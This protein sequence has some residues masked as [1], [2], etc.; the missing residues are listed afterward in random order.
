[1][2]AKEFVTGLFISLGKAGDGKL[3]NLVE[4]LSRHTDKLTAMEIAKTLSVE[5]TF[6]LGPLLILER[7]FEKLGINS[8]L[9]D[10]LFSHPQIKFNLRKILFTMV[11]ARFVQAGSKLKLFEHWQRV[12]YPEMLES[13]L[14]LHQMYRTLDLLARHKGKLRQ[15]GYSKGGYR[16]ES[17]LEGS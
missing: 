10:I 4:A 11:S 5:K 13:D 3:E 17:V 2:K 7:L 8:T 9:E 15:F 12:F 14:K 6:I 1:M 16:E